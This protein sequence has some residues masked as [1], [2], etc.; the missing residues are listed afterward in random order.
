MGKKKILVV[1]DEV[2]ILEIIK[3]RLEAKN[4]TVITANDGE[5]AL[6]KWK[7][8]KPDALVLDI[9]MPHIDGLSVLKKIREEDKKL[10]IFIITAFSNEER[11]K[12]AKEYNANG[13]IIK[14]GDLQKEI[15]K[16][17]TTVEI[18]EKYKT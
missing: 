10:P 1:D 18:A 11:I 16:I 2:D 12:I 6:S 9:M 3:F 14:T 5:T 17:T 13:F 15:D 4:Y 7:K 8:E